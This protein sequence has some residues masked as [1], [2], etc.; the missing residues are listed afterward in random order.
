MRFQVKRMLAVGTYTAKVTSY[1][2]LNPD[3]DKER[4][5]INVTN[6]EGQAPV[7]SYSEAG[8]DMLSQ[9]CN[10]YGA[11]T[12]DD[13]VGKEV[14]VKIEQKGEYLNASI[15]TTSSTEESEG[16]TF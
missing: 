10:Y 4:I 12:L 9:V 15:K 1:K 13:L 2:V 5:L 11:S 16:A 6:S 8:Y 14:I 3:T 7:I